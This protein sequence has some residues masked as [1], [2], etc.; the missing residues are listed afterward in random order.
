MIGFGILPYFTACFATTFATLIASFRNKVPYMI[1]KPG[2]QDTSQTAIAAMQY[3]TQIG[4]AGV[5][6]RRPEIC[7]PI[8]EPFKRAK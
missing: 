4:A 2:R 7:M 6:S 8:E 1:T 5:A 3:Y